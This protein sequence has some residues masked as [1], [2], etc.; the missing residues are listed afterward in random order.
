MM[1]TSPQLKVLLPP[2]LKLPKAVLLAILD[3]R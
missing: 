1:P 3:S 2:Q